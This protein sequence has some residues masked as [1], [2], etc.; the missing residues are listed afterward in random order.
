MN[1]SISSFSS[2]P[3]PFATSNVSWIS[4]HLGTE[5]IL[6]NSPRSSFLTRLLSHARRAFIAIEEVI[7]TLGSLQG[8]VSCSVTIPV[9]PNAAAPSKGD[10]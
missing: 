9:S 7:V 3:N 10:T 5:P 2:S 1:L 8:R 6:S 4:S